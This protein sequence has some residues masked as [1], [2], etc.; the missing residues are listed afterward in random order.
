[1]DN[2]AIVYAHPDDVAACIGGTA[3]LLKN[4]FKLHLFCATRG[5]RGVRKW[6][7]DK[8]AAVRSE[9]QIAEAKLLDAE[10]TFLDRIDGELFADREICERVAEELKSIQPAAVFT[11]W[12]VDRHPDHAASSNITRKALRLAELE[13]E[14]YFFCAGLGSQ[15]THFHPDI[16]VDISDVVKDKTALI[17]CHACQNVED[18]MV[19][20]IL[21]Q[22]S[23]RAAEVGIG[24]K[25]HAEGFKMVFPLLSGR[26]FILQDLR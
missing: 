18:R 2:I 19:D 7:M 14:L 4:R 15:T 11:L 25:K 1:M 26:T 17:R 6:D 9:E 21:R 23:F 16:Y 3:W 20:G 5:E 24:V 12:P 22:D 13:C 10:L 8:T